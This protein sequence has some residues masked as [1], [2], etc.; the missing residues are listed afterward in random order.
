MAN[1]YRNL[2]AVIKDTGGLWEQLD[3]QM[4][5]QA[6]APLPEGMGLWGMV[7][8]GSVGG[9]WD[10][11]DNETVL[12]R[13]DQLKVPRLDLWSAA[14]D[15]TLILPR[16]GLLPLWEAALVRTNAAAGADHDGTLMLMRP[17]AADIW[18]KSAE[19]TLVMA[20]PTESVFAQQVRPRDL[21]AFRP[22]RIQ[23]YAL[24][25]LT[26]ARGETYW[27][28]KNLRTD[29]YLRLTAEQVFLWEQMDGQA[30][31]QDIAV[32]H[33]LAHG[34]LAI[35]SL[36]TLLDQLQ[37][38]GF[39]APLIDVYGAVDRSVTQRRGQALWRRLVRAFAHTESL[40][41]KSA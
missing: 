7:V 39:I 12:L 35:G 23:G 36:L 25:K 9:V 8:T 22:R 1:I 6:S 2:G 40:G 31:V 17:D 27:I 11:L 32:A 3:S 15:E 38:K 18:H 24:K 41:V 29:A 19:E 13:A 10:A 14:A 34:K 37:Q 5:G 21:S 30:S 4:A 16:E 28:L 26:D 33:M 20:R